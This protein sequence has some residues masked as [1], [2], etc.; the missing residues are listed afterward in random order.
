[1]RML[2]SSLASL[3]CPIL[4]SAAAANAVSGCIANGAAE[5]NGMVGR[6]G[7]AVGGGC[8]EWDKTE[9]MRVDDV[10]VGG[11]VCPSCRPERE[12]GNQ[13]LGGKPRGPPKCHK[14]DIADNAAGRELARV[15]TRGVCS[16]CARHGGCMGRASDTG[17]CG[18]CRL[19]WRPGSGY[20]ACRRRPSIHPS[21]PHISSSSLLS[22][23]T[24]R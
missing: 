14:R 2:I 13:R 12:R 24:T 3:R 21:I 4:G 10:N 15:C 6:A 1:M 19:R 17:C 23:Y 11:E 5:A 8:C 22:Q 16:D 9:G 7:D 18:A 20:G